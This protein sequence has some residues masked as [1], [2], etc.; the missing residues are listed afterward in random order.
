V[1]HRIER[2]ARDLKF[3][4]GGTAGVA[5]VSLVLVAVAGRVPDFPKAAEN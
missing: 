5:N 1:L 2:K 3:A 4:L